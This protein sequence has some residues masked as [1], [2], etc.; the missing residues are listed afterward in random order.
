MYWK[1]I[2]ASLYP[3]DLLDE[4]LDAIL[5][6][7]ERDALV[8]STYLVALMHD[9]KRPLTDFYYPHN[10]RRKVYWTEDSR[11]YW[12]PNPDAYK[13]SRI[14]PR[15]SDNPELQNRDWLQELVAGSR[16]RGMTVGAELSHTWVDKERAHAELADCVQRDI[17]GQPFEQHICFN[18]PDVRA[19]GLA[20]YTD[21]AA[22]YDLDF[23]Q[24]CVIGFHS[25]R[26][27]PWTSGSESEVQRLAGVVLGGCFCEHCRAAAEKGISIG[28]RWSHGSGGSLTGLMEPITNRLLRCACFHPAAL[29]PPLSWLKF[30]NCIPSSNS[31]S[32]HSPSFSA[33]FTQPFTPSSPA[34][35]C[36]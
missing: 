4:G 31:A 28:T 24:T 29:P 25:G 17:F 15:P 2:V 10:P 19:Y 20:L 9:E 36:A 12:T 35:T 6:V 22:H 18:H 14:K 33:R 27:Q 26:R 30:L 23:I 13:E 21:L 7:L 34:L 16:A 5:D 3:W 1:E 32:T 11:A 8:N